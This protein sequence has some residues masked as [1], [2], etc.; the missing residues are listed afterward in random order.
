MKIEDIVG[1]KVNHFDLNNI[2][3]K[4][5]LPLYEALKNSGYGEKSLFDRLGVEDIDDVNLKYLPIYHDTLLKENTPLDKFIIL[6]ILALPLEESELLELFDY[7]YL[8][9]LVK[10]GVLKKSGN[11]YKSTVAVFPCVDGYFATDHMFTKRFAPNT[12][13]PLGMDSYLLARAM[14]NIESENTLD[15]CT[16][17]GVHAILAAKYSKQVTGVDKNPRA[18]NFAQFNALLNQVDNTRFLSGDL[19][20]PIKGEKYDWIIANP[21]FVPSPDTKLY[22]RHGSSSGEGISKR[23]VAGIPEFLTNKG[24]AQL[25]SS[26]VFRQNEDYIKKLKGWINREDFH[27]LVLATRTSGIESYILDHITTDPTSPDFQKDLKLWVNAYR[28]NN[29]IAVADGLI[30]FK[31]STGKDSESDFRKFR[32]PS[33][34]DNISR[35]VLPILNAMECCKNGEKYQE[36]TGSSFK[37]ADDINFWWEGTV[38]TGDKNYGLLFKMDSLFES[39]LI[40]E[41]DKIL[42]DMLVG[43]SKT[44]LELKKLFVNRKG[45]DKEKGEQEFKKALLNMMKMGGVEIKG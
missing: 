10:L 17:C 23:V 27:T 28:E 18:V 43:E 29:I 40:E 39:E 22:F 9:F 6:F 14:L 45:I 44:E 35:K 15:M 21:P 7:S 12:V 26:L 5:L 4:D 1:K 2:T 30:Y 11:S 3:K 16:G 13:Y 24:F 41:N 42:L 25:V 33:P 37:I 19:Y 8:T 32:M 31:K 36:L 34:L 38:P 20:E